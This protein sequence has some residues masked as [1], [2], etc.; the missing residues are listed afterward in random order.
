[1]A[2][3]VKKRYWAF[4]LY[5][6]SAPRDWRDFI[7]Q[8]GIVAAVSPLHDQDLNP[9]GERKKPHYHIIMAYPGPT[10]YNAVARLTAQLG[11]P[12]PQPL[13]SIEGYYRYFTHKDNPEKAQYS[14]LQIESINGFDITSFVELSKKE[15]QELKIKVQRIVREMQFTEYAQLMDYLLDNEMFAEY[16][17]ACNHTYFFNSYISSRKFWFAQHLQ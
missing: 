17:V 2:D 9:T 15:V 14:E 16:D 10:T 4:V 11:Q 13:E 5:P 8:S 3:N 7:Q 6:E 1:M 12:I